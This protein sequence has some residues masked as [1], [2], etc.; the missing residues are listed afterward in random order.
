MLAKPSLGRCA[1]SLSG[2]TSRSTP[3]STTSSLRRRQQSMFRQHAMDPSKTA[4]VLIEYQNEFTSEGGKLHDAVK[5]VME[6][7]DMLSKSQDVVSKARSAGCTIVHAPITFSDDYKELAATPYGILAGVKE[8]GC[9]KKSEWGGAICDE[10][11]PEDT[12]VVI[13]G[14]RGLDGFAS[15][16]LDFVLRQN[17]IE[18]IV[19]G[20]F[21]TNCCVESTMRTAYEK[22]YNVV[23]LTDCTAATS[24]EE[25]QASVEKTYPMFSKPM[26]ASDFIQ[27]ELN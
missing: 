8:G 18:N 15:T 6:S 25:Q 27:T 14:K 16:N 19:L 10:M 3:V 2:M 21:L 17:N 9:F 5:G 23:T 1:S 12:D 4:V 20:G 26:T 13:E 11:K 7:N 24:P 22:G